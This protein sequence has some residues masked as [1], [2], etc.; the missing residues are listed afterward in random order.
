MRLLG[1]AAAVAVLLA[2]CAETQFAVDSTKGGRRHAATADASRSFY[3]VGAPYQVSGVWYYPSVDYDYDREGIASWYGPGFHGRYTANGEVYDQNDVTAAHPTLPLPSMV[4]VTNLENGRSLAVRVNDRGPFVDGR[5]IDLSRRSA[6]LLGIERA[7][8]AHVRVQVMEPESRQLAALAQQ[9]ITDASVLADSGAGDAIAGTQLAAAAPKA[10][11]QPAVAAR[12]GAPVIHGSES[13]PAPAAYGPAAPVTA[14]PIMAVVST[15]LP[16]LPV[17]GSGSQAA[18]AQP[19][20]ARPVAAQ[21]A[22]VVQPAVVRQPAEIAAATPAVVSQ[23]LSLA[24]Q[25]V[26]AVA[27]VPAAADGT[28]YVW[29]SGNMAPIV[30]GPGGKAG[31]APPIATAPAAVAASTGAAATSHAVADNDASEAAGDSA[32]IYVQAGAF[33]QQ[34]NADAMRTELAAIGPTVVSPV[35]IGGKQLFR[36]RL[37]PVHSSAEAND[38]LQQVMNAGHADARIVTE[39]GG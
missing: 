37:G 5:I 7:G 27:R 10:A 35:E 4:R 26:A 25:P 8:V 24:P 17:A 19:V 39:A 34:G 13:V 12:S 2:G 6:Q 29:G 11:A 16:P 38:L 32:R 3:K 33:S 22:A 36:V 18:V 14:A 30:D 1:A 31:S 23:P 9:G 21:P 20:A 15:A 28:R